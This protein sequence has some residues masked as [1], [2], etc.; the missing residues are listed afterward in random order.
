MHCLW[1]EISTNRFLKAPS[2][3]CTQETCKS[4]PP[5]EE[6]TSFLNHAAILHQYDIKITPRQLDR[7]SR[8]S[9]IVI[10]R[11]SSI[12]S[13]ARSSEKPSQLNGVILAIWVIWAILVLLPVLLFFFL[14]ASPQPSARTD[15][16]RHPSVS[17]RGFRSE[18]PFIKLHLPSLCY[19]LSLYSPVSPL[20]TSFSDGVDIF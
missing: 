13:T 6:A 5:F 14:P 2:T 7:C 19:Y 8:K 17:K 12:D 4:K 15:P 3:S 16:A 10:V 20:L 18:Q 1:A 9:L 11:Y